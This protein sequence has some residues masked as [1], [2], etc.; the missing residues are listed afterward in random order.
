MKNS[1]F[2]YMCFIVN[3]CCGQT[4]KDKL[5]Q[6]VKEMEADATMR[7]AIIGIVV[8]DSKTGKM[9]F[10]HNAQVGLAPAST[11][12]LFTSCAAFD[13]LGN[14][15]RYT[16][17]VGY[18][19]LQGGGAGHFFI[20]ASGD[21]SF[22]SSR[23]AATR[24]DKIFASI[25]KGLQEKKITRVSESMRVDQPFANAL[26]GGWMWE[27]IGNYYGAAAQ[28]FN[29]LEN[30]YDLVLKSGSKVG[31][32]AMVV[33]IHPK[34][35]GNVMNNHM[36][37][38]GS[39]TSAE[40]SSGD[41]T[42]IYLPYGSDDVPTIE[43][44]IPVNENAFEVSGSITNPSKVFNH[45]L[46]SA[47]KNA[48]IAVTDMYKR[49]DSTSLQSPVPYS[50]AAMQYALLYRHVSPTLDSLNYWFLKKS[51]NLYGEAF[52][53]TMAFQQLGSGT[54]EK[55]VALIKDF[56]VTHGIEKSAVNICDGSGLSPQNRVTA[57][58][59]VKVLQYAKTRPWF[60]SFYYALPT[61]NAMK[62]KS[63][64]I[65][66]ARAYAG[67]HTAANGREYSFAI[68]VNNYDGSATAVVKKMYRVLDS[69]K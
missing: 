3:V 50:D 12:K 42:I 17:E 64:S 5:E 41:N 14:D 58:A 2:V 27:D 62:M 48:G 40:K 55:G 59:L 21:P 38:G 54:T 13:L 57:D 4:I 37:M 18:K 49:N 29:W 23:F 30:Q 61:Y 31:D 9:I 35:A 15:Y 8:T 24:P 43:G 67:Y 20:T 22:G 16:T 60:S 26:P 63:G 33:G 7:H 68:I 65:G 56:W 45:Q 28:G 32:T 51:I 44:T 19:S 39:L 66:G 6:S 1:L 11:Q 46:V 53:K 10:E 69:L 25:V 52:I 36:F 47:I 34:E